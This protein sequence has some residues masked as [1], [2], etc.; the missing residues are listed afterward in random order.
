MGK[1]AIV[2]AE[3]GQL[4]RRRSAGKNPAAVYLSSLSTGSH[5]AM[6]QALETIAEIAS[7]GKV[8]ADTFPWHGVR[9][10]HAQAIRTALADRYA[11]ATANK[12]LAALRGVL[13]AAWQLDLMDGDS[14]HRAVAVK[15]VK[16]KTLPR[17]RSLDGGELRALFK[18][19]AQDRSSAGRRD[20]ALLSVLYG[21]GV[22]RSEAVGLDLADYNA[23]TGELRVRA[24]KG[25][26]DRLVY[27]TNGGKSALDAWID[28]RGKADGPLFVPILKSGKVTARRL[29]DQAVYNMLTKRGKQ[30]GIASFSP[31]DLRRS[32]VGDLLD[33]GAD[34]ALVQ[35][36]TGH[37]SPTTT[38]QYDRRPEAA[39]RRAA[40][41]LHVP[42]AT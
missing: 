11:P 36:L 9:H 23:E 12:A 13:R 35:Q 32:F 5:R 6:K 18:A 42:Y 28:L 34:L 19:C 30:A 7:G 33:A 4:S 10:E 16:G 15:S 20:A 41:L 24:G 14:Y 38:S 26:K 1:R 3:S 2:K 37:A 21:A 22:R 8:G 17:G 40:E 31:H 39:K 29:T 25:R 27:A